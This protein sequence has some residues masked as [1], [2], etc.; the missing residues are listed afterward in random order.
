MIEN[1]REFNWEEVNQTLKQAFQ[2]N[3]DLVKGCE[4]LQTLDYQVSRASP[5]A[6][7]SWLS[8]CNRLKDQHIE[9]AW[10]RIPSF[11]HDSMIKLPEPG[12]SVF[13]LIKDISDYVE[14]S[15]ESKLESKL[16]NHR[17]KQL[18]QKVGYLNTQIKE[19]N[20]QLQA[21]DAQLAQARKTATPSGGNTSKQAEGQEEC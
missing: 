15:A 8:T 3:S 10:S 7:I 12:S 6:L 4:L 5:Q 17:N 9:Q 18:V 20:E 21:R 13:K 14:S 1:E 11:D 19:L 16:E 2:N